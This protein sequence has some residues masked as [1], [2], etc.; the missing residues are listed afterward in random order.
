MHQLGVTSVEFGSTKSRQQGISVLGSLLRTHGCSL[1]EE[2]LNTLM[3]EVEA[4]LNS[5]PLIIETIADGTSEAAISPRNLFT[6]KSKIVM[7]LPGSFG[8]PDFYTRRKWRKIQHIGNKF[9][10][11]LKKE[12]LTSLQARSK[13]SKSIRNLTVADIVLLKTEV[14]DRNHMPMARVIIRETD[15]NGMVRAGKLRVDKSQI[16]RRLVDKMVLLLENEILQFP[17]EKGPM[18]IENVIERY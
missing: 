2:A 1:N 14:S 8:T 17:D 9:W 15:Q 7:Q 5:K 3:I 18:Y 10:S 4:I 12:F 11:R 16:L 6:M 13:W